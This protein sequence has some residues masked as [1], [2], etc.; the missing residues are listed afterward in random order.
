[1]ALIRSNDRYYLYGYDTL[2]YNGEIRERHYRVDKLDNIE[3]INQSRYGEERFNSFDAITYVSRRMGMFPGKEHL[4]TVKIPNY[5]VGVFI[6]Q[7]GKEI[8]INEEGDKLFVTFQAVSSDILLGWLIGLHEVEVLKPQSVRAQ[9]I[10]LM[11]HN[12]KFYK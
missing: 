4:I 12:K 3:L 11:E 5:M 8:V 9:I 1:M 7:F 2:E 10:D 6:D